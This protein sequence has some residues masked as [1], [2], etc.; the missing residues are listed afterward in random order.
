[1]DELQNW[2]ITPCKQNV[3]VNKD[4]R[5]LKL[6]SEQKIQ[7]EGLLHNLPSAAIAGSMP[8]LYTISFPHGGTPE[9]L[10]RLKYGTGYTTSVMGE[11]GISAQ[12]AINPMK[13]QALVMG[14]FTIM[15]IATSQYFL[16]RI[17]SELKVM[18]ISLDKIL[19]FL[20]G[21][22]KAEL[23]SEVTFIKYAYQNYSSIMNHDSQ[24]AATITSVQ[25]AKKVAMKDIEFYINDLDSTIGKREGNI[26]ELAQKAFQIKDSLELSMQLYGI[27]SMLE[28]YF[29][30]NF[31]SDYLKYV[32]DDISVY[33]NKC[34]KRLLSNFSTLKTLVENA[35]DAIF[36]KFNDSVIERKIIDFIE[37]ISQGEKSDIRKTVESALNAAM[38][39]NKYF[40]K[41]DGSVYL[42]NPSNP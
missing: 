12:A 20:Y 40:L 21:D 27:S 32:K 24:K 22:K 37:S 2:G 15:S 8:E 31:D 6:S 41:P 30:Q 14:C 18:R 9:Q 4:C 19:E 16:K 42:A 35:K 10:M 3:D 28:I 39:E 23:M 29:S 1:M 26:S 25:N 34:E 5:E 13:M 36:N 17:G 7:I 33:L 38:Q 11:K